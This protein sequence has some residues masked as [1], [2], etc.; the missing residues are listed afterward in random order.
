M[1]TLADYEQARRH[2]NESEI[3]ALDD[4]MNEAFGAEPK[5]IAEMEDYIAKCEAINGGEWAQLDL[6][7]EFNS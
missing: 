3:G 4:Y 2:E 7:L 6:P 1:N 5:A